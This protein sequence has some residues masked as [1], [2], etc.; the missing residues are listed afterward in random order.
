MNSRKLALLGL[1]LVLLGSFFVFDIGQYLNLASLKAQ[2]AALNSQVAAHPLL[3]A[4]LFFM[5]YV[6]V[7]ALSLPGAALMTLLAGAL[8]GLLQGFILV[9][10]AS[11]LGATLAMLSSRFLLRDWV[12]ARFGQRLTSIDQG[13]AREGAFY[14]FA[15][16]LVPVFP[17]FLI[18][19]A[20]GLTKLPVRTYWWVSQLGML[21]G[22]LVY[23]NAGRELGQLDSLSG[24][25]S[26]G[27][28]GAF[29]LLGLF[30]LVARKL[31]EWVKAR[32]VYAGW[33]KPRVFDRNLMVIGAGSGGL[34]SAYIA[35]AV[36]AKVTLIEKHKMGGDC[37]NTGCVPSKALLRSAKL[38]NEMKKAEKLG[39][40]PIKA[41]VDFA[42]VMQR[43]QRVVAD[44]E[45]H[46]SVER[47]TGLG[48]EVIEGEAKMT[49]PW[50]VEVNGQTLTTRSIIIATGAR[51]LVP[52]IPGIEQ[53]EPLTS[54]NVWSL[55]KQPE[56]LLVL[57]GGPIGC[58][59]AQ[60]FQRLGSNVTQVEM[61]DRLLV[62]EDLEASEAV[63]ASL[64]QDG[65][66]LRLRHKAVR[67][68]V[69]GGLRELVCLD[70][71]DDS[72]VRIPFD[73]VL[74]AL[75]RV[76]NVKGFGV[77]ALQLA[78]RPNG[79]LEVDEYLATRFPNVF[80][81]GDVTGPYQF[82]HTSAHQAWFAAVNGLF[83]TFKRFK[84]DYRVIPWATF[85]DP[86]VAR[87]GLNEQ[88]AKEQ[89]IAYEVSRFGID[90]LDRAIA[91]EAAHGYI[92]VL[93]EPGK[94]R[95]LGVTIV[96]EHAGELIAEYVAA[97]KQGSGLN[98]VLGTI[99]IYPTMAEA[100]KYVAGEWKRAHAPQAVLRWVARFHQWRLGDTKADARSEIQ[101]SEKVL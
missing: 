5:A 94:D 14:L 99:H 1:I 73:Q 64:R 66:D 25:L 47:Y 13:I 58:E 90:D 76:A 92:K 91:D 32:K 77:E 98:K 52:K 87:V 12:Q 42:A 53:V 24:I 85:T 10:F 96:G 6:A 43:V 86:E 7:T 88:D 55:R 34:V 50:T 68:E 62:R 17:F 80:A 61:T 74:L 21:P 22:T 65:V 95:I 56:R 31:L 2:Q 78:V 46:D 8:F 20:M 36:K 81:V 16:R 54:D 72:E 84:V 39:F 75:G 70:L 30:P 27:L 67:F 9:S 51:P 101:V 38:A 3:A 48:V 15:L 37:L 35:A 11:T 63:M 41:E 45:P 40:K 82:T 100:N 79:T 59:L 19:L 49:S 60:A 97:M 29:V 83:G 89:G 18:N 26:P 28:L 33:I 4:G 23:V 57:G 93:T 71:A 44:V 69:V